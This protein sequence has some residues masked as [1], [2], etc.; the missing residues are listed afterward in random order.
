MAAL[1][2]QLD[3]V[4]RAWADIG[5]FLAHLG[6]HSSNATNFELVGVD[7][8]HAPSKPN[9][10]FGRTFGQTLGRCRPN[11]RP[12]WAES[13]AELGLVS[14]QRSALTSFGPPIWP[15]PLANISRCRPTFGPPRPDVGRNRPQSIRPSSAELEQGPYNLGGNI[16]P[17][18]V[19]FGPSLIEHKPKL[20]D[21]Q[22]LGNAGEA[23][24][25]SQG[26]TRSGSNVS[27]TFATFP[28]STGPVSGQRR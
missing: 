10:A 22:I 18:P 1:G 6:Q 23:S 27:R 15:T 16:W 28:V 5:P 4:G 20:A 9:Q 26:K 11:I 17:K 14:A 12:T 13:L 8:G 7:F 19:L 2:P 24:W 25:R 3:D 21:L